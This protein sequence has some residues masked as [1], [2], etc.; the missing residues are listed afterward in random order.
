MPNVS[1][2]QAMTTT[3][4]DVTGSSLAYTPPTGTQLVVYSLAF[5]I[6]YA[7]AS[8]IVDFKLFLDSDEV[9]KARTTFQTS[10][11]QGRVE[12]KWGFKIGGSAD[13]TIGQIASWSSAK[14]IKL[15]AREHSSTVE[16]MLHNQYHFN[17]GVG[18]NL[19]IP[20][21]SITAI[22]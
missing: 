19:S 17:G 8:P 22:K 9:T 3:Y 5:V 10:Y 11:D 15:Q 20:V 14:T 4:A 16:G 18:N 7:D 21:L 13:T 12:I 2:S 6:G 1:A